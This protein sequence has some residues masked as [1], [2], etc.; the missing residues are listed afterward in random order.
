MEEDFE[1]VLERRIH[2][3][4]N[5]MEGV[6]HMGCAISPDC[7]GKDAY[8]KGLRLKH[9]YEVLYA[10]MHDEFGTVIDNVR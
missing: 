3:F 9:F 10:M 2:Y 4:L 7:I 6:M 1:P 5:Y 8:A